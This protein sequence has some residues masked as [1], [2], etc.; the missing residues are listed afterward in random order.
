MPIVAHGHH[1]QAVEPAKSEGRG[2]AS[3]LADCHHQLH[4]DL[5]RAR[6]LCAQ[7]AP[8]CLVFLFPS[9]VLLRKVQE[10]P[11]PGMYP[12]SPVIFTDRLHLAAH[13]AICYLPHFGLRC[14]KGSPPSKNDVKLSTITDALL[15]QP[16]L[17]LNRSHL[18]HS[19]PD[20][21]TP[22]KL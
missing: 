21:K 7:V 8:D 11:P 20:C 18:D 19:S 12:S 4:L 10:P 6:H 2:P 13:P 3:H 5:P 17:L 15:V 9:C 16:P 22:S 14:L 1:L